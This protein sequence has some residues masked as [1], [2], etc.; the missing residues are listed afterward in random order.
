MKLLIMQFPPTSC[1]FIPLRSKFLFSICAL[2]CFFVVLLEERIYQKF[3]ILTLLFWKQKVTTIL[4]PF[5]LQLTEMLA[6]VSR[7]LFKARN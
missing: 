2:N 6:Y 1:H 5:F 7:A 4:L 3:V